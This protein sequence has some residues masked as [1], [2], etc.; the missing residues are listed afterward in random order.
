MSLDK[1][2]EI[3]NVEYFGLFKQM[4]SEEEA[5]A[6]AGK[7]AKSM[8][9]VIHL[10]KEVVDRFYYYELN[11][12]IELWKKVNASARFEEIIDSLLQNHLI[13]VNAYPSPCTNYFYERYVGGVALSCFEK[14]IEQSIITG[15]LK[16]KV[17]AGI[18]ANY[19]TREMHK[20][21]LPF[22]E[23]TASNLIPWSKLEPKTME[24]LSSTKIKLGTFG[25]HSEDLGTT[26][27]HVPVTI[28]LGTTAVL[29]PVTIKTSSPEAEKPKTSPSFFKHSTEDKSTKTHKITQTQD[30]KRHKFCVIL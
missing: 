5:I 4:C 10:D 27:V 20:Y 11:T 18:F 30:E 22:E 26:A 21:A 23:L 19:K 3:I 17:E 29:V 28:D 14:S 15:D 9:D 16:Q 1:F 24:E 2:K 12:I 13:G 8:D 7:N 25:T 6:N